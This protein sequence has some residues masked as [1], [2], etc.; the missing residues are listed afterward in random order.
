MALTGAQVY[1]ADI[2]HGAVAETGILL[3]SFSS[4][5]VDEQY[6]KR[7]ALGNIV[8]AAHYG[9]KGTFTFEGSLLVGGV[10]G[11][12]STQ[13]TLTN[14]VPPLFGVDVVT[15]AVINSQTVSGSN[16]DAQ[17][18]ATAGDIYPF[19]TPIPQP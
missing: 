4:S 15:T 16:T 14:V 10:L 8:A 5:V 1:G 13:I 19:A 7:D 17:K 11:A 3:E 9:Q 2:I 18:V 6:N 12:V